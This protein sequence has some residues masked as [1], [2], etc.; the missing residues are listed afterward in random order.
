MADLVETSDNFDATTT[1]EAVERVSIDTLLLNAKFTR[2]KMQCPD[3]R[4]SR[5]TFAK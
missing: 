4:S 3:V 1:L 5:H 2:I